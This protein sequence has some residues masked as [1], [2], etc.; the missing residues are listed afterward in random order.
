VTNDGI[1]HS[2]SR[3]LARGRSVNGIS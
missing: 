1:E 3:P 2:T